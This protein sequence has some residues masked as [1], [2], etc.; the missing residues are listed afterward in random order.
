[1]RAKK[2]SRRV[3]VRWECQAIPR[4]P[5][6]DTMGV[7]AC[8][9]GVHDIASRK[10]NRAYHRLRTGLSYHYGQRLRFLT[11]TLVKDSKNDIHTCFR[12]FKERVRRLTPNKLKRKEVEGFFLLML[13]G[14]AILVKWKTGINLSRSGIS[15]VSSM[16]N[17]LTCIFSTSETGCL[18]PG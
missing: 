5:L 11:L 2:G 10:R 3:A 15:L 17:P 4:L 6:P 8:T 7:S 14:N 12:A 18:I 1:M 9:D 16:A 13:I